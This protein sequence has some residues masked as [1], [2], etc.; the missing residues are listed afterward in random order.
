MLRLEKVWGSMITQGKMMNKESAYDHPQGATLSRIGRILMDKAVTT[1]DDALSLVLSRWASFQ[2]KGAQKV[3]CAAP[4]QQ[5][6]PP[7]TRER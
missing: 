1:K 2:P 5:P 7:R 6:Q 4:H 3:P